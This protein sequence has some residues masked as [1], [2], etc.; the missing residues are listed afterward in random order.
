MQVLFSDTTT[1][2]ES[3]LILYMKLK[4]K[5]KILNFHFLVRELHPSR[6]RVRILHA[7]NWLANLKGFDYG[8]NG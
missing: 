6:A 8:S 3:V 4:E 5:A 2:H 7:L 1:I